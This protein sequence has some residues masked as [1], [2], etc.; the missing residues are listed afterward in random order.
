M[1]PEY[2]RR[3]KK[4]RAALRLTQHELAERLRVRPQVVASWEQGRKVPS[5]TSYQRLADLAAPKD[6][7]FFLEQIGVTKRL[8]RAKWP[9][10]SIQPR[11][12]P[13]PT[14]IRLAKLGGVPFCQIPLLAENLTAS[15][16]ELTSG[17]FESWIAVPTNNLPAGPDAYIAVRHRDDSMEPVLQDRFL[18]VV[19]RT[20]RNPAELNGRMV[21]VWDD[22]GLQFRWLSVDAPG[23]AIRLRPENPSYLTLTLPALAGERLLGKVIF[24]WGTQA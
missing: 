9:G 1:H 15:Q 24:W 6:A 20:S 3:I 12:P 10:R 11:T 14:R 23:E 19:D 5:A 8:V 18:V 17:D 13:P 7:W 16:R 2:A 4:L 21:A 22:A